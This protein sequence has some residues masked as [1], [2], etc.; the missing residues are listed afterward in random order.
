MVTMKRKLLGESSV[1]CLNPRL[2]IGSLPT[3]GP[4]VEG[5]EEVGKE[6]SWIVRTL[7]KAVSDEEEARD[8]SRCL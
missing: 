7:G 4:E 3:T 6:G 2:V 1:G 8:W 5:E